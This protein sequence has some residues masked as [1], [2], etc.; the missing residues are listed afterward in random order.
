MQDIVKCNANT[1]VARCNS[2]THVLSAMAGM[3]ITF[4]WVVF[5]S[6]VALLRPRFRKA[7]QSSNG[8]PAASKFYSMFSRMPGYRDYFSHLASLRGDKR[9][10][11]EVVV[12][13][14]RSSAFRLRLT[15]PVQLG[16]LT[17]LQAGDAELTATEGTINSS[18]TNDP[19]KA[20]KVMPDGI[21]A[22]WSETEWFQIAGS[23]CDVDSIRSVSQSDQKRSTAA[24][25][26]PAGVHYA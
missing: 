9:W 14:N 24:V 7:V 16:L 22:R 18:T 17:V 2:Y 10:V 6:V 23:L 26:S 4:L 5:T 8:I 19:L 20:F 15:I 13:E 12:C 1:S 25:A 3:P 11:G 21:Q